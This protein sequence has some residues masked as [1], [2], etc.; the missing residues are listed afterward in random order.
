MSGGEGALLPEEDLF[1]YNIF[2]VTAVFRL[3]S[4]MLLKVLLSSLRGIPAI[5]FVTQATLQMTPK[6]LTE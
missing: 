5:F 1:A 6:V 2:R 4:H 3:L